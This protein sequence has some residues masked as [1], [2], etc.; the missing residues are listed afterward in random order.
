[1]TA[2]G[3]H[4]LAASGGTVRLY[5]IAGGESQ[6]APW[7][8]GADF[9]GWNADGNAFI[10]RGGQGARLEVQRVDVRRGRAQLSMTL[11]P[12]DP[13]GIEGLGPVVVARDGRSYC[14]TYDRQLRDLYLVEGLDLAPRAAR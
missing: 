11:A 2:D 12:A 5:A 9:L 13:V 6:A 8:A 10:A 3:R 4:F 14:Y 7:L 1:V